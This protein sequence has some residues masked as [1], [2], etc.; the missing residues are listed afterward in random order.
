[1]GALSLGVCNTSTDKGLRDIL[2][3]MCLPRGGQA[4]RSPQT[5]AA[6]SYD[7]TGRRYLPAMENAL[8]PLGNI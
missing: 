8:S 6:V 5:S 7:R 4:K 2:E 3:E 1:M